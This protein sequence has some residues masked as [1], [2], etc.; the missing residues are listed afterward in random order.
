MPRPDTV[1]KGGAAGWDWFGPLPAAPDPA[2]DPTARAFAR[3]FAGAEGERAIMHLRGLTLERHLG[4]EASDAMLRHLE[5]QRHL[6][7]HILALIARGR[8]VA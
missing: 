2:T 3:C 8:G 6:V 5:G 4:P 7:A 1:P